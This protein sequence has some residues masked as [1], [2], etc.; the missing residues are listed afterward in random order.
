MKGYIFYKFY[1]VDSSDIKYLY[2]FFELSISV[3]C[4]LSG[5]F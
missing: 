4:L 1:F 5:D 3:L 2:F